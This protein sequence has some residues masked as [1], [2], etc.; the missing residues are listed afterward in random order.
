MS[1]GFTCNWGKKKE[2]A[3]MSFTLHGSREKGMAL[4]RGR[5]WLLPFNF[6]LTSRGGEGGSPPT[7]ADV[8][9]SWDDS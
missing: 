4:L 1:T 8:I 2:K 5:L 7:D 9:Y 3:G 6:T